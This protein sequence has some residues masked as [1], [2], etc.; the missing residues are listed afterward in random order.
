MSELMKSKLPATSLA[1]ALA[2]ASALSAQTVGHTSESSPY[3]DV[4]TGAE[5][6]LFGGYYFAKKDVLDVVPRSGPAFGLGFEAPISGPATFFARFTH[7][8]SERRAVNPAETVDERELGVHS[9]S[10]ELLDLG[11]TV[12]LTGS[13]SYH[14][15]VPYVYLGAGVI[16][17]RA[18]RIEGDPFKIGTTFNFPLGL[19]VR[20]VTSESW[21]VKVDFGFEMHRIRYPDRYFLPVGT[22]PAVAPTGT[23]KNN[24][25]RDGVISAGLSRI[26]F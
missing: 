12:N 23:K 11:F 26:F 2:Y 17:D 14:S 22:D 10:L 3:R 8:L 15:M 16:S 20:F 18:Q 1:I 13:K 4:R 7:V 6:T 5:F 19:G 24:W 21:R 9:T 25:Y